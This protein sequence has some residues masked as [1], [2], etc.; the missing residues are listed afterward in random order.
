[1]GWVSKVILDPATLIVNG[2]GENRQ[3]F[4]MPLLDRYVLIPKCEVS[5]PWV[6]IY[7]GSHGEDSYTELCILIVPWRQSFP[8]AGFPCKGF[9]PVQSLWSFCADSEKQDSNLHHGPSLTFL[10]PYAFVLVLKTT[11]L[12]NRPVYPFLT[13]LFLYSLS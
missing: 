13:L 2:V 12:P 9:W 8:P 4:W 3:T 11:D 1:M 7:H 10:Y 6:Q 5:T